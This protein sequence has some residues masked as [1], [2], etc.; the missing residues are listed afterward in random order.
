M[1]QKHRN[2][3]KQ[4][5]KP[6][7]GRLLRPPAWKWIGSVLEGKDKLRESISKEKVKKEGNE[8]AYD[9]YSAEINK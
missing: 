5:K 2:K 9:V 3:L 6:R 1:H 8:E 7:F 4:L